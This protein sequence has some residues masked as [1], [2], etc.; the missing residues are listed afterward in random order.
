M[1]PFYQL[2]TISLGPIV[3][4][5][6][7]LMVAL[8]FLAGVGIARAYVRRR[9]GNPEFMTNLAFWT[10]LGAAIGARVF[11]VA[12]YH[13]ADYLRDPLEVLRVWNGGLSSLGGF[14]GGAIAF[15]IARRERRDRRSNLEIASVP[16]RDVGVP[17]NDVRLYAD[18]ALF[19]FPWAWAIGR[20]GCFLIHDH[21]GTLTHSL[22]G[23]QYPGGARFDLGFIEI[24]NAL[25]MGAMI[26][27]V[28][29][30]TKREDLAL[31][32]GVAWYA[33][34]RFVT[35]FLRATDLPGSDPRYLGLTPAQF[36][37]ILIL[38]LLFYVFPRPQTRSA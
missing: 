19:S 35:D 34:V 30:Y 14:V 32:A 31:A 12:F 17:R 25:G 28:R 6:W 13:P 36:G 1:I 7:G 3:I 18:A 9:G 2:T 15:V 16:R 10:L 21:P 38:I 20:V 4:H 27:I 26:L 22:L 24:L 5:A 11:H 33:V 8:G 23:V 37:M 29:R